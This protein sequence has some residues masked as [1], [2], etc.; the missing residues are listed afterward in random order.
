M[1]AQNPDFLYSWSIAPAT[2]VRMLKII[3]AMDAK[4]PKCQNFYGKTWIFNFRRIIKFKGSSLMFSYTRPV[5]AIMRSLSSS[6]IHLWWHQYSAHRTKDII[7][8]VLNIK[9][10]FLALFKPLFSFSEAPGLT[11]P[12][13]YSLSRSIKASEG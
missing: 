6:T 4:L 7:R 9:T 1:G 12:G 2:T 13:S 8:G 10:T 3:N 5:W 11:E